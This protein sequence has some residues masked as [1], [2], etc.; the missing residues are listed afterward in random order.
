[1]HVVSFVLYFPK[2]EKHLVT[3]KI[4]LEEQWL[5]LGLGLRTGLGLGLGFFV[6]YFSVLCFLYCI[7]HA[8]FLAFFS[9]CT[10]SLNSELTLT[11]AKY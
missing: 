1:M 8:V 10:Y 3:G 9:Y 4:K 7:F 2:E 11:N 6:L 5:R